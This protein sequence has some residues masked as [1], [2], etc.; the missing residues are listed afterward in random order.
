MEISSKMYSGTLFILLKGELDESVAE[1]TKNEM[2]K[3][4]E[5]LNFDQVVLDLSYLD[6]MDSTGIGVLI[7]RYKK[8]KALNKQI[9]ITNPST[10]AEKIF[11]MSGLYQIMPK[12][13]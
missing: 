13:N 10:C 3:L 5:K 7:G 8:L 12:I 2:D 9:Y 6:F 4:F 1:Y 11:M